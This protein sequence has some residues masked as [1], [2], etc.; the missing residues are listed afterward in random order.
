MT[1]RLQIGATF[2]I[3]YLSFGYLIYPNQIYLLTNTAH[4]EAVICL[5]LLQLFLIW[6]YVKGLNYFPKHDIIDILSQ[7]GRWMVFVLLIPY[8][9]N[10][11][12]LV[13]VN[14]RLHTVLIN[15]IF[16]P[17]TPYWPILFL[18][19]SIS[20]YT[21]IKGIGTIMRCSIFFFCMV[22]PIAIFNILSSVVNFDLH[23]ISPVITPTSNFLLDMRFY[24]LLGFSSFLY[25]GFMISKQ[26]TFRPL[27]FAWIS[28]VLFLLSVVYIPLF[29]FGQ[30]TAVMLPHPFVESM[31]SIDISW[32]F[33]NRQTIFF[34]IAV[35]GLVTFT[36]SLMLWMAGRILQKMWKNQIKKLTQ[37][38]VFS[39]ILALTL[40]LLIPNKSMIDDCFYWGI[41]V[42]TFSVIFIPFTIFI[43]GF[44]RKKR[45]MRN[46][47]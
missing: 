10:L 33:F 39:S 27:F 14:V 2:I 9:I 42:H 20:T 11:I 47:K 26:R 41:R 29:I 38:I 23:N 34:G 1:Q 30:E 25:L 46:E 31:D 5:G 45:R 21:A 16:L 18:L 3:M 24:Y 17:R 22:V 6:I 44:F 7:I 32:F 40:S 12:A 37:W 19:M 43:Y 28:V 36:N 35:I 8:V 13:A 4:W 15:K